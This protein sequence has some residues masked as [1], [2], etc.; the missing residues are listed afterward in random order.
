MTNKQKETTIEEIRETLE[1]ELGFEGEDWALEGVK[2][3]GQ[4]HYFAVKT[5]NLHVYKDFSNKSTTSTIKLMSEQKG[6]ANTNFVGH[7]LDYVRSCIVEHSCVNGLEKFN[8][9]VV[10]RPILLAKMVEA[11]NGLYESCQVDTKK[12]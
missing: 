11:I 6:G 1:K 7:Q 9:L 3:R 5:P 10:E 2:Y 4:V 12:K 8:E